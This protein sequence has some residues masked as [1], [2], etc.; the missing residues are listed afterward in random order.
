MAKKSSGKITIANIIAMVGLVL[1]LVFSFIGHSYM[2]GGE[3]GWDIVISVGITIFTAFLLWF[4]I[5][6][7]G[8]ENQL[9]KWRKIEYATLAAY[10]IFAVPASL[11]GGIM[12]FFVV[13]DHKENI[14]AYAQSDLS[15]IETLINEYRNYEDQA[16]SRTG[17]GLCNA[18]G[19]GQTCDISL[20]TFMDDNHISHT[21][22]SAENFATIQRSILLGEGFE[23]FYNNILQ[24]K[25][26]I[27]NAIN[28]WS[29]IQIPMKAKQIDDLAVSVETELTT[30][31]NNAQLPVIEKTDSLSSYTIVNY[32]KKDFVI[33]CSINEFQF[34]HA[35]KSASGFSLTA[36]LVVLLIHVLILFNYVVAYR[37]STLGISKYGEEDG[38]LILK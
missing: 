10:I 33:E 2:S 8:A 18:V 28:S 16:I 37:T 13:N 7:K 24:E 32:Q 1:L 20:N 36:L 31:S 3:L 22:E 35:L 11:F 12:H 26:E 15:K 4:L 30:L 38:G 5:K 6:S 34:K 21:R 25:N 29:I 23:I 27:E 14:K 17:T 9:E 19:V